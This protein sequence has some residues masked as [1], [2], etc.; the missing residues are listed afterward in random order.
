MGEGSHG[1]MEVVGGMD[2]VNGVRD[3]YHALMFVGNVEEA[4]RDVEENTSV[5][6]AVK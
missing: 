4:V 1:E 2:S 3:R 5:E 6:E